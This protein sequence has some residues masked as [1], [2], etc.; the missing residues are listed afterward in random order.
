MFYKNVQY[1][2]HML[3]VALAKLRTC[4]YFLVNIYFVWLVWSDMSS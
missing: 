4:K 2:L 1:A 3:R